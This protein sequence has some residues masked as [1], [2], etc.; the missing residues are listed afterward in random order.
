LPCSV[1]GG[2]HRQVARIGI[3]VA[4]LLHPVAVDGLDE[5]ALRIE[6]SDRHK[7]EPFVAGSLAVIA[8][9]DP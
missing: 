1:A 5:V 7:I 6:K 4:G 9:Q 3:V 8:R 2:L